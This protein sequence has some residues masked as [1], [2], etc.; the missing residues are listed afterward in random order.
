MYWTITTISTVGYGDIVAVNTEERIFI[1]IFMFVG[2]FSFSY[3]S[4]SISN[5]I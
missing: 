5:L 3:T 1:S 4:G 2:V